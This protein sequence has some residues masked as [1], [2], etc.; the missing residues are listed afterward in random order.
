MEN[1]N[2]FI[3]CSHKTGCVHMRIEG[4]MHNEK[5]FFFWDSVIAFLFLVGL[6]LSQYLYSQKLNLRQ[7]HLWFFFERFCFLET[8]LYLCKS[9]VWLCMEYCSHVWVGTSS[10]IRGY[11]ILN[12]NNGYLVLL[13]LQLILF[14]NPYLIFKV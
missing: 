11:V 12:N 3:D 7:L 14:L 13:I 1:L 6:S 5:S 4:S 10:C 8:V 9:I 2:Y